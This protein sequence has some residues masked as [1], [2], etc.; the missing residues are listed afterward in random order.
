[1]VTEL[2]DPKFGL[3]GKSKD[4]AL[5]SKQLGNQYFLNGDY[6]KALNYYTQV[7]IEIFCVF[8]SNMFQIERKVAANCFI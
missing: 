2:A 5:E 8:R 6:D 7:L 1:M 3:C 4:A